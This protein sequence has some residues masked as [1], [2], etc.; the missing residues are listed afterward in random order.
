M[1]FISG[2][3][4]DVQLP[5]SALISRFWALLDSLN[6]FWETSGLLELFLGTF[7]TPGTAFW[8]LLHVWTLFGRCA[9]VCSWCAC[10]FL[11]CVGRLCTKA[12]KVPL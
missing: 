9:S 2:S 3:S 1:L 5:L 12:T 8:G 4:D 7:W 6:C 10:L 11:S